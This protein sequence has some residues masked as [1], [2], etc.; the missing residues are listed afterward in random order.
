[1]AV[2]FQVFDAETGKLAWSGSIAKTKE[3]SK[4]YKKKED[5]L[6]VSV[7]KGVFGTEKEELPY[8]ATP[9]REEVLVSIF[10]G[11]AANL[12]KEE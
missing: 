10:K 9:S 2:L 6:F 3:E 7:V 8:P 11:F 12:P 5:S 4:S 1:M